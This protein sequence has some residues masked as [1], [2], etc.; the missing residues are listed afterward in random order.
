MAA[1]SFAPEGALLSLE[2]IESLKSQLKAS[3]QKC[4]RLESKKPQLKETNAKL[5]NRLVVLTQ[6]GRRAGQHVDVRSTYDLLLRRAAGHTS[7]KALSIFSQRGATQANSALVCRQTYR[8][9]ELKAATAVLCDA[10]QFFQQ[11]ERDF[12]ECD[13]DAFMFSFIQCDAS[14]TFNQSK[15]YQVLECD[16]LYVFDAASPGHPETAHLNCWPEPVQLIDTGTGYACWKLVHRQLNQIDS[17]ACLVDDWI[18]KARHAQLKIRTTTMTTDDGS[19]PRWCRGKIK[20]VKASCFFSVVLHACCVHHGQNNANKRSLTLADVLCEQ[21]G[22]PGSTF[23]TIVKGHHMWKAN[24]LT[25]KKNLAEI[26]SLKADPEALARILQQQPPK[27]IALRWGSSFDAEAWW[28]TRIPFPYQIAIAMSQ[29]KDKAPRKRKAA[30]GVVDECAVDDSSHWFDKMGRWEK[31]FLKMVFDERHWILLRIGHKCREP[32]NHLHAYL[33]NDEKTWLDLVTKGG[34][35][36]MAE[37]DQCLDHS[38]GDVLLRLENLNPSPWAITMSEIHLAVASYVCCH[39]GDL[40]RRIGDA[41]EE[42]PLLFFWFGIGDPDAP[43]VKRLEVACMAEQEQNDPDVRKLIILFEDDLRYTR[44]NCGKVTHRLQRYVKY[45][46][47]IWKMT[48]QECESTNKVVTHYYKL[49]PHAADNTTAAQ[50]V[51][52]KSLWKGSNS[53]AAKLNR[54]IPPL[55]DLMCEQTGTPLFKSTHSDPQRFN[56][57]TPAPLQD[58]LL[59][60][61][62]APRPGHPAH[63]PPPLGPLPLADAEGAAAGPAAAVPAPAAAA[64]AAPT[65][66][67]TAAR[68]GHDD[69]VWATRWSLDFYWVWHRTLA[70]YALYFHPPRNGKVIDG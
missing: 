70:N 65:A 9:W 47:S 19:D 20:Q 12:Q 21:W 60:L 10:K 42:F 3:Q 43:L 61:A 2:L 56:I 31:E 7:Y 23:S 24:A 13:S 33:Q 39:T 62:D 66:T 15:K 59:P 68:I 6:D 16:S 57:E 38:W 48:S 40:R 30:T 32:Y 28:V 22:L 50:V 5:E 17:P 37:I 64:T 46:A 55:V 8:N 44:E 52:K 4:R 41:I 53:E 35:E 49:A 26:P 58:K 18:E 67:A 45:L 36:L 25:Y 27:P 54:A 51:I 69:R 63:H 34:P 14:N 1:E 29:R 11:H